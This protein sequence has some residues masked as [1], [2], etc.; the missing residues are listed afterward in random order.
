MARFALFLCA[1]SIFVAAAFEGQ[2]V[3]KRVKVHPDPSIPAQDCD[4]SDAADLLD[5]NG[6]SL[7]RSTGIKIIS[8]S[9]QTAQ[10]KLKPRDFPWLINV[11]VPMADV[12]SELSWDHAR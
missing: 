7:I 3:C 12:T 6:H 4:L 8:S 5:V 10:G 1:V 11:A 2:T 9:L